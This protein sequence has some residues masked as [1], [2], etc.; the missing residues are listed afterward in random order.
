M[1]DD[2]SG[3]DVFADVPESAVTDVAPPPGL[4]A[5]GSVSQEQS[6]KV[7]PIQMGEFMR[8]YV[9]RRLHSL[10]ESDMSKTMAAMRQLGVGVKGGAEALAIFHQLLYDMWSEGSLSRPMARIKV[11]EKNCFGSLEWDSVRQA[12]R[13]YHPKHAAAVDWKHAAASFVEQEGVRPMPKDR[14]A[15]QG[16][17]DGPAECALTLG[18]VARDA[19][20]SVHDQQ[21]N[22]RMPWASS[23]QED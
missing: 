13:Q 9:S 12:A 8:K 15:E 10:N 7:R 14:G 16:D 1:P 5:V 23:E 11:D 19:R 3:V 17:V 2:D 6:A 21:R 18:I 22:G 20:A 4:D